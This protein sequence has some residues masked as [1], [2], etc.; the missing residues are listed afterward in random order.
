[1]VEDRFKGV[2]RVGSFGEELPYEETEFSDRTIDLPPFGI[3]D[4]SEVL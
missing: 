4:E 3:C 2:I 1:M